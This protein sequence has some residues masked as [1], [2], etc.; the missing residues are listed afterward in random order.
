M[1]AV[2]RDYGNLLAA[3]TI[4]TRVRAFRLVQI[5]LGGVLLGERGVTHELRRGGLL[6]VRVI[7]RT[8]LHNARL[9]AAEHIC[10]DGR[11]L[12]LWTVCFVA[13]RRLPRVE[14]HLQRLC[15]VALDA[16]VVAERA[17]LRRL[18]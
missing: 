2:E 18:V 16:A 14:R 9:L 6:A 1:E 11:F 8:S 13:R 17:R 7:V 10:D 15:A 3:C 12:F 5:R 4:D